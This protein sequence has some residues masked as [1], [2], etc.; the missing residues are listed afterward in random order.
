MG[1]KANPLGETR[2]A[3]TFLEKIEALDNFPHTIDEQSI[4]L[5]EGTGQC[6][7]LILKIGDN[8]CVAMDL[9]GTKLGYWV[10]M[11]GSVENL[12]F[13]LSLVFDCKVLD[14]V[15]EVPGNCWFFKWKIGD[16][17]I[18]GEENLPIYSE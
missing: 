13:D 11:G 10:E 16:S 6:K 12:L 8:N 7:C 3:K 1:Q 2:F 9:V 14:V 5:V 15:N 4:Y 18:P 17:A